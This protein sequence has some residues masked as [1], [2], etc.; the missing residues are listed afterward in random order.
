MVNYKFFSRT[1]PLILKIPFQLTL[2]IYGNCYESVLNPILPL[3]LLIFHHMWANPLWIYEIA[4]IEFEENKWPKPMRF[5]TKICLKHHLAFVFLAARTP[6]KKSTPPC[7]H[8][9]WWQFRQQWR[10][11]QGGVSK[12]TS[13]GLLFSSNSIGAVSY[14]H[15]GQAHLFTCDEKQ[16]TIAIKLGSKR[17]R[18]S[19]RK[20]LEQV[21][22]SVQEIF[23]ING[24]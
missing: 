15:E 21:A 2:I 16:A 19:S 9:P 4:P 24:I 23:R 13:L 7:L 22:T 3:S 5:E 18:N 10:R 20:L 17:I 11:R 8:F 6:C 1:I 12:R 14:I